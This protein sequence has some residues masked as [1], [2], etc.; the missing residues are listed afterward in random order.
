MWRSWP[1]PVARPSWATLARP[2]RR[3]RVSSCAAPRAPAQR[4]IDRSS[5]ATHAS[6]IVGIVEENRALI[7]CGDHRRR[8]PRSTARRSRGAAISFAICGGARADGPSHRRAHADTARDGRPPRRRRHG[9]GA[10]RGVS[11]SRG[12]SRPR[13]A[14]A[15]SLPAPER[16]PPRRL[17]VDRGFTPPVLTNNRCTDFAEHPAPAATSWSHPL[18][19]EAG[20]PPAP[21]AVNRCA[22]PNLTHTAPSSDDLNHDHI[23]ATGARTT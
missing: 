7:C 14:R 8:S 1:E 3:H 21:R 4:A 19:P 13:A 16:Q 15:R 23:T 17:V 22:R 5:R 11:R 20:A 18:V 2:V 10:R 6:P 9:R 12:T